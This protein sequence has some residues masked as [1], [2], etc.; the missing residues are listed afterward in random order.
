MCLTT[1]IQPWFKE[2]PAEREELEE[3]MKNNQLP[4]QEEERKKQE[5]EQKQNHRRKQK[6]RRSSRNWIRHHHRKRRWRHRRIRRK[7]RS[8]SATTTAG[9]E[10]V[11]EE[12]AGG[13]AVAESATTTGEGVAGQ[14]KTGGAETAESA[15]TTGGG[16]AA[17]SAATTGGGG[18]GDDDDTTIFPQKR[19]KEAELYAH[20][21]SY[22][23][24][25]TDLAGTNRES[26]VQSTDTVS[27]TW[28]GKVLYKTNG[29]N[30]LVLPGA[31]K[32]CTTVSRSTANL[33]KKIIRYKNYNFLVC[34]NKY[35]GK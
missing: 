6:K 33:L 12:K 1:I 17:E 15:V 25:H 34:I 18:G 21:T 3:E 16:A 32:T 7:S 23:P 14:E 30:S 20:S 35:M 24:K 13:W 19:N 22:E 11:G 5:E 8:E 28:P 27:S 2:D 29:L 9:V 4:P 10:R 26:E 31:W